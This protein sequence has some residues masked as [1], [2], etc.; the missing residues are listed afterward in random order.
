MYSRSPYTTELSACF[1]LISFSFGCER[2]A[3]M[4]ANKLAARALDD[5]KPDLAVHFDFLLASIEQNLDQL[6]AREC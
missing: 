3:S 2:C 5:L 6:D 1:H 4:E